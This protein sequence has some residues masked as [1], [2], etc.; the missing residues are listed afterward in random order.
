MM[1]RHNC[2]S[3]ATRAT[4][5]Q[6]RGLLLV[7]AFADGWRAYRCPRGKNVTAT[8]GAFARADAARAR[9]RR[10]QP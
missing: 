3:S 2:P 8:F 6:G 10:A 4:E 7:D 9:I 5:L 1:S